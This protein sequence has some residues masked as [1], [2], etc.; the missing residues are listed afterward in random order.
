MLL[1]SQRLTSVCMYVYVCMYS[2]ACMLVYMFVCLFACLYVCL[3][4][5]VNECTYAHMYV[6]A[7]VFMYECVCMS[8]CVCM[9]LCV[10]LYMY[11]IVS[12]HL[13]STSCSAHQSEALPVR[14]TQR[15]EEISVCVCMYALLMFHIHSVIIIFGLIGSRKVVKSVSAGIICYL[16]TEFLSFYF[17]ASR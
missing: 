5:C 3:C 11:C 10:C 13:Y 17:G 1:L 2:C 12:I 14:E 4:V 7:C 15:E 9:H 8:V 6:L 16:L